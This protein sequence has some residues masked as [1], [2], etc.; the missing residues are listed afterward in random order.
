MDYWPNEDAVSWFVEE[1]FEGLLRRWPALRFYIVGSRPSDKVLSLGNRAGVVV[2]G[3]VPSVQPYLQHA[4]AVVAPM[5]IAR[6]IQNKVLEAMAMA[7]PIVVTSMG[8]EGIDAEDGKE[9]LL[10]DQA[11][12]FAKK[13]SLIFEGKTPY[14]GPNARAMVCSKFSWESSLS[15]LGRWLRNNSENP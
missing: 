10:A 13:L 12:D 7:K 4:A 15:E 8:L 1:V 14:L 6:G 9:V 11:D 3:R 5:R 2:T